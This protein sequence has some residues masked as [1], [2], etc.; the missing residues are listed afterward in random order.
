MQ[1]LHRVELLVRI[2]TQ[3]EHAH[4]V[5]VGER[6]R[7]AGLLHE[8]RAEVGVL[9]QVRVHAL[10]RD[11]LR[12]V[13]EAGQVELGHPADGQAPHDLIATQAATGR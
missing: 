8:H 4:D 13:V 11:R 7:D 9:S 2:A 12:R 5:G 10:D 1:V 3:L 6:G